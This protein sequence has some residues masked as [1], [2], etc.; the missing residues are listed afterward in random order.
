MKGRTIRFAG[1]KPGK[2][3]GT[4]SCSSGKRMKAKNRIF[5][6]SEQQAIDAGY[7]PCGH[8]V[9]GK[10]RQWKAGKKFLQ[11]KGSE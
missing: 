1:Y 9:P 3:Y 2:I 5:F 8:C 4:L 7:R 11:D 6:E 10:Y